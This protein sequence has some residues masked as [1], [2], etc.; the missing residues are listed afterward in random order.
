[1]PEDDLRRTFNL[2]VGMVLVIRKRDLEFV[3]QKLKKLRQP[4]HR[5][6][7]VVDFVSQKQPRVAY[8]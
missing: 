3:S 5:I 4:F 6:G 2:G 1:V 8:L 7:R